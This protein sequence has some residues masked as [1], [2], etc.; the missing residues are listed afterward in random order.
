MVALSLLLLAIAITAALFGGMLFFAAVMAPLIFRL[1]PD[2]MAAAFIRQVFPVYY[3][4]MAATAMLGAA[5]AAQPNTI[6]AALLVVVA[7]GF[8]YARF[9]IMPRVNRMR[10]AELAGEPGAAVG[11]RR[12]HRQSVLLNVAQLLVVLGVLLFLVVAGPISA[13]LT[14]Q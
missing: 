13:M 1:L 2:T 4:V 12:M 6:A 9:W 7:V 10:D 14:S 11:F 5:A 8:L 3:L